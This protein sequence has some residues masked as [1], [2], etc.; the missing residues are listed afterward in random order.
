MKFDLKD[1]TNVPN[2]LVLLRLVSTPI[3]AALMVYNGGQY[4]FWGLGV[5]AVASITDLFDG[6]IARKFNMCTAIGAVADPL[7]DKVMH[8]TALYSLALIGYLS[9]IIA[10]LIVAKELIMII[11]TTLFKNK[12]V[13]IPANFYGKVPSALISVGVILSFFHPYVMQADHILMVAATML[14][15][16]AFVQYVL[17]WVVELRKIKA[18]KKEVA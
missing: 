9:P 7:A 16:V 17:I 3:F 15:Y 1:L 12:G 8:I 6:M 18:G 10:G 13:I 4:I 14:A 2:L 5:F 11:C